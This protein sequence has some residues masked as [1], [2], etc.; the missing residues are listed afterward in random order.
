MALSRSDLN[1]LLGLQVDRYEASSRRVHAQ[2]DIADGGDQWAA[3]LDCIQSIRATIQRLVSEGSIGTPSLDVAMVFPHSSLSKFLT[4]PAD[5]A[6]AAGEAGM[7]V[8]L[9]VYK[10]E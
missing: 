6:A 8:Q 3:A 9:S 7:D 5:L 10:T 4:V 2:I 1:A